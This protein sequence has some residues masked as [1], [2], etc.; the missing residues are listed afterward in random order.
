[1]LCAL[2]VT[3]RGCGPTLWAWPVSGLGSHRSALRAM[4]LPS[5]PFLSLSAQNSTL[6]AG[7]KFS[8]NI[9]GLLC[10]LRD[11]KRGDERALQ[12]SRG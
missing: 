7:T 8:K 4:L 2:D 5:V 1:M 6:S 12:L 3:E 10:D 9:V 11:S